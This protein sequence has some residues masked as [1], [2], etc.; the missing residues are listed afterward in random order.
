MISKLKVETA[1]FKLENWKLKSDT[2]KVQI[3]TLQ[4][5][6]QVEDLNSSLSIEFK[7]QLRHLCMIHGSIFN[8]NIYVLYFKIL[9]TKWNQIF[10]FLNNYQIKFLNETFVEHWN[11][12]DFDSVLNSDIHNHYYCY[13]DNLIT[14]EQNGVHCYYFAQPLILNRGC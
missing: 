11:N 9:K 4:F 7:F 5:D 6:V 3:S 14:V 8:T 12:H 1:K 10:N 13:N 2:W